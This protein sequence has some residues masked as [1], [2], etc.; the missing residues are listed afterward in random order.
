MLT[1]KK[2]DPAAESGVV[3][4]GLNRF[5][6]QVAETLTRLGHEVLAID[7]NPATVQRWSQLLTHAVQAD[8]TDEAALRQVGVPDFQRVVVAMGTSIET[9]ILTVVAL[10]EIG[11]PQIWARATS[12]KHCKI[13]SKVGAHHVIFPEIAMGERVAHLVVSK[14]L[15]FIEFEDGYAIAKTRAP[16]D[17]VGQSLA[18]SQLVKRY[19]ITVVGIKSPGKDFESCPPETVIPPDSVLIVAGKTN[20]V[21]RFASA[22]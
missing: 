16:R 17:L 9:S 6:G 7:E 12:D 22:T 1:D 15:D 21:E 4:V 2:R 13:L 19:G 3:V 5:G 20:Q 8:A 14:L 11:V 18:R 10:A